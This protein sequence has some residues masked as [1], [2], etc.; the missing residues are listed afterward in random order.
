MKEQNKGETPKL[1]KQ[2]VPKPKLIDVMRELKTLSNDLATMTE[3]V[4]A[5]GK[6]VID[7]NTGTQSALTDLAVKMSDLQGAF[8]K[9]VSDVSPK[10]QSGHNVATEH[11]MGKFD[12]TAEKYQKHPH[13]HR[14]FDAA[15]LM[16]HSWKGKKR[17]DGGYEAWNGHY[18]WDFKDQFADATLNAL[19]KGSVTIDKYIFS[20]KGKLVSVSEAKSKWKSKSET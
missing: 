1:E 16:N 5:L 10:T 12:K 15:D 14:Q 8:I 7:S 13:D 20:L 4:K 6:E 9:T 18:G 3:A 11:D 17:E 19:E 2:K